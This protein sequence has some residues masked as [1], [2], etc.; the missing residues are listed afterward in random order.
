[1]ELIPLLSGESDSPLDIRGFGERKWAEKSLQWH[2]TT[3]IEPVYEDRTVLIQVRPKRKSYPG[4]RDGFG[5]H[6]T[7]DSSFW[8]LLTGMPF[9]PEQI[10]LDAGV[11]EANEELRMR[12][13]END[14]QH[15]VTEEGL[16]RVGKV[17]IFVHNG[18]A[19]KERST[20]YLLPIPPNCKCYPMD[21]IEGRFVKVETECHALDYLREQ[22]LSHK[23]IPFSNAD[24]LEEQY[25]E[26]KRNWKFA[27][28][29]SRVFDN[30]DLFHMVQE[31]IQQLQSSDFAPSVI[32]S[33]C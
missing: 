22:Y 6:V 18:K 24:T 21:D 28:G 31:A 32:K 13:T 23:D 30:D 8:P 26:N 29:A 20:L 12:N 7:L 5:G 15:I 11:R 14:Y 2:P 10:I 16:R 25:D 3:L 1:M 9:V 33:D 17:G 19:N 27:D 4:C